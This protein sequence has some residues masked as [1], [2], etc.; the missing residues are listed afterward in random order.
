[1]IIESH[2]GEKSVLQIEAESDGTINKSGGTRTAHPDRILASVVEV[3][4]LVERELIA[5]IRARGLDQVE[6]EFGVHVDAGSS[7]SIAMH[8]GVGQFRVRLRG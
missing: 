1:M 8:P 3:A 7:V 2:V 5:P 6:I 4:G